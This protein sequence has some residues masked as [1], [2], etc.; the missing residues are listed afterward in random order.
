MTIIVMDVQYV[1]EFVK[2]VGKF[3]YRRIRNTN[4]LINIGKF[5][6]FLCWNMLFV[7]CYFFDGFP[8]FYRFP[9][10]KEFPFNTAI[11]I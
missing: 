8:F 4:D 5:D 7:L 2:N 1:N 9:F 11:Y 10:F 6:I 3:C